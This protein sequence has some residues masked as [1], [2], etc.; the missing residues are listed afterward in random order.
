MYTHMCLVQLFIGGALNAS[1]VQQ[2]QLVGGSLFDRIIKAGLHRPDPTRRDFQSGCYKLVI[3]PIG[4][5]WAQ[6]E[7]FSRVGSRVLSL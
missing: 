5:S 3:W 6:S 7:H 2:L 4:D 1:H